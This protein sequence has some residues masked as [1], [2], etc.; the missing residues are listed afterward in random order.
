MEKEQKN[1]RMYI[2]ITNTD[3]ANIAYNAELLNISMTEYVLR[4]VRRKRIVI[5]EDFPDLILQLS[6]IGNN[7][8]QIA[9]IGNTNNYL[10]EDYISQARDYLKECYT[11]MNK[12][13]SFIC[14]PEDNSEQT[15]DDLLNE[16]FITE[17]RNTL[18]T[19]NQKIEDI[20]KKFN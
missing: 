17:I 9:I 10:S 3:K 4:C 2:R 8:N 1:N 15:P 19:I 5:V 16:T 20:D 6:K 18:N 11:V 7:L 12:F 13:I 14:E